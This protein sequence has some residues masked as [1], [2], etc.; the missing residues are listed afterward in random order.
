MSERKIPAEN[1]SLWKLVILTY[2]VLAP[3]VVIATLI[4]R[5]SQFVLILGISLSTIGAIG[6]ALV[7][8]RHT[9]KGHI[10]LGNGLFLLFLII[11]ARGWYSVLGRVDIWL[12]WMAVLFSM[13]IFAWTLPRYSPELSEFLFREQ[14]TP[15]TRLGKI[16]LNASAKFL[17]IAGASGALLGMYG[18]R[19]GN[20]SFGMIFMGIAGTLLSIAFAQLTAHQFWMEDQQKAQSEERS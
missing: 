18:S 12:I 4:P 17:P 15:E 10:A 9:R 2:A 5:Y 13:Y 1:M 20:D 16:I 8:K 14:Y 6:A 7:K 11:G 3:W 19:D